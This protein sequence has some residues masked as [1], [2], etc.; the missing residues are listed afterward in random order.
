MREN[1]KQQDGIT[2]LSLLALNF[3]FYRWVIDLSADDNLLIK[4]QEYYPLSIPAE[5]FPLACTHTAT[6]EI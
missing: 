3:P 4:P 5:P 1:C 6:S 2:S